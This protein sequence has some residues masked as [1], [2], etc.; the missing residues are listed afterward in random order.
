MLEIWLVLYFR[1]AVTILNRRIHP[2]NVP[3]R[4]V[5][6]AARVRPGSGVGSKAAPTFRML[7]DFLKD[8][9]RRAQN[10]A[11]G[12]F[13]RLSGYFP[14]RKMLLNIFGRV[15]LSAARVL[16]KSCIVKC[17]YIEESYNFAHTL[18]FLCIS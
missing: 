17:K 3:G 5:L 10:M 4:V 11:G 7:S 13:C 1:D 12:Q 18:S 8:F 2:E 6:F 15:V 14:S 9:G 16:S